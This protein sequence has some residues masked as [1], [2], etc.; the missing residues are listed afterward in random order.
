M[1]PSV[2]RPTLVVNE[3]ICRENISRMA[4]KAKSSGVVFRPH[5]KTHQS[6]E[7]ASWFRDYGVDR[8]TVSSAEMAVKFARAGWDDITLAFPVNARELDLLDT[9]AGQIKLNLLVDSYPVSLLIAERLRSLAGLFI[10]ID[11]G[12]GRSGLRPDAHE[13]IGRI[14]A[15]INRSGNI[16][17]RGFL[18]HAG[19]SYAAGSAGEIREIYERTHRQLN[20][21]KERYR[22][23]MISIGDT[24]SCSLIE[25][26]GGLDEIRPGN[27]V[28]YDLMQQS[29]GSCS[30]SDIA[31][32]IACPVSG[33]YPER[34]EILVYGGAVHLSKEYLMGN[35]KYFGL[36]VRYMDGGWT[37]PV[38]GTRVVSLSQ[39]HG[40]IRTSQTFINTVR[41]GDLLGILPVH[42]CLTANLLHDHMFIV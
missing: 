38:P 16:S 23:T 19:E 34:K 35:G 27:F 20:I 4:G 32:S 22:G 14:I 11:T 13:E 17:F 31:V 1:Y 10:E 39:E 24:P 2:T 37:L 12:Y 33:I 28:Y 25:N 5:F 30:Y 15:A 26:F 29:L 42:S 9:L 7:V 40:I 6:L 8:I 18:T 21:L 3:A 41:H 36:V